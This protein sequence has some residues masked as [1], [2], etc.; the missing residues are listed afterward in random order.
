MAA[1]CDQRGPGVSGNPRDVAV[2]QFGAAA[3]WSER[4]ERE[5]AGS[6]GNNRRAKC[7]KYM[8]EIF[9]AAEHKCSRENGC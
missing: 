4:Q 9:P 3:H 2:A 7:K 8:P 5:A 1:S 6:E